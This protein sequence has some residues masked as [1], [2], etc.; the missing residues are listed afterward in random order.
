MTALARFGSALWVMLDRPRTVVWLIIGYFALHFVIRLLVSPVFSYDESEQLQFSQIFAWG[1]QARHPPLMTWLTWTVLQVSGD[2]W[3]SLHALKAVMMT[4]G[5]IAFFAAARR[6]VGAVRPAALATIATT[7]FYPVGWLLH[8]N[9]THTVVMLLFMALVLWAVLV[10]VQDG[11]WRDYAVLGVVL[12]LGALTKYPFFLFAGGLVL[13]VLA[14]PAYRGAVSARGALLAGTIALAIVAP[15][16]VWVLGQW[17]AAAAT[18]ATVMGHTA[19]PPWQ[20]AWLFIV[21]VLEF[22]LPWSVLVALFLWPAVPGMWRRR[23]GTPGVDSAALV[24]ARR[25]LYWLIGGSMALF[26]AITVIGGASQVHQRWMHPVFMWA[27]ILVAV[28][29]QIK[30]VRPW[31]LYGFALS[32]AVLLVAVIGMRFVHYYGPE[33]DG[34][35][36]CRQHAPVPALAGQM[37]DLGFRPGTVVV[38]DFFLGGNLRAVLGLDT[39]VIQAGYP[40]D[41]FAPV[42]GDGDC[43]ATWR[44]DPTGPV[45]DRLPDEIAQMMSGPLSVDAAALEAGTWT[46]AEAPMLQAP[47]RRYAVAVVWIDGGAGACR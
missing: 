12:G 16:A 11:R 46:R 15:H 27:P 42:R 23:A 32:V 17:D 47:D 18:G 45:P 1:Y 37:L 36:D 6:L 31:R 28:V 4:V 40:V 44:I 35:N 29:L 26:A 41:V 5:F 21:A 14:V 8:A 38:D 25:F 20:S 9:L 13:A 24:D 30:P 22:S 10:V 33:A 2:A 3:V 19:A 43:L 39:R 34:C 7:A